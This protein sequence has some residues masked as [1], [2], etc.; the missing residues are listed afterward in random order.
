MSVIAARFPPDAATRL[1]N[2]C[3]FEAPTS[4]RQGQGEVSEVKGPGGTGT[5]TGVYGARGKEQEE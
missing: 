5:G 1:T 2:S 4:P 3:L